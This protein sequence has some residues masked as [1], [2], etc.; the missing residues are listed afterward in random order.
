[1][2][3]SKPGLK[4][5]F[6]NDKYIIFLLNNLILSHVYALSINKYVAC[7]DILQCH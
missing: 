1:M 7:F 3:I 2:Q 4:V 6:K 5:T